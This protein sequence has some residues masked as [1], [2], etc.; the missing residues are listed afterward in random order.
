MSRETDVNLSIG[1]FA[2]IELSDIK[3][4]SVSL[5]RVQK[6][7]KGSKADLYVKYFV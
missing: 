6:D 2:M 3:T 7:N 5:I 4:L 1:C